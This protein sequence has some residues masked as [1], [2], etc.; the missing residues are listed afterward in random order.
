MEKDGSMLYKRMLKII[1][2]DK[3]TKKR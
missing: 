3:K 1:E 2:A